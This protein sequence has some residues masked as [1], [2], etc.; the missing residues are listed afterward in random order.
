MNQASGPT[1]SFAEAF[2]LPLAV[3]LRTAAR[4]FGM[5]PATAYKLIRLGRFPCTVLRV[6]RRYR[7]PTADMLRALGI[8]E[9]PVYADVA[10]EAEGDH[11]S[12]QY[13]AAHPEMEV[14]T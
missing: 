14:H 4:A 2:D 5:C 12:Q 8:E 3:D 13:H 10:L 9:R 7:I 1:L 6:G 11:G